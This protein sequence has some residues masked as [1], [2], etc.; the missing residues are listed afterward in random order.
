MDENST[1]A[2]MGAVRMHRSMLCSPGSLGANTALQRATVMLATMASWR[3]PPAC[4]KPCRGLGPEARPAASSVLEESHRLA[5]TPASQRHRPR[6]SLLSPDDRP[7]RP[8]SHRWPTCD[9]ASH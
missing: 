7:L 2:S 3:T 8:S 4:T 9:D 1:T 5:D 6:S